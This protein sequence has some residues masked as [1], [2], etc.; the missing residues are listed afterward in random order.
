MSAEEF[1]PGTAIGGFATIYKGI[2]LSTAISSNKFTGTATD[3]DALGGVAAA[4]YLRSNV[5]DTTTGT[6]GVLV[7]GTSLTLGA[8]SDVTFTMASDNL[9][10]SPNHRG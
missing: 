9:Y 1:T 6:L 5:N 4:N 3:A 8:G 10:D 7:D 2:T